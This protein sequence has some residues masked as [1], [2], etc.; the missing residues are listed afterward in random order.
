[1]LFSYAFFLEGVTGLAITN[2]VLMASKRTL[3][4]SRIGR[5]SHCLE[6]RAYKGSR[7]DWSQNDHFPLVRASGVRQRRK[8]QILGAQQATYLVAV[9]S[10]HGQLTGNPSIEFSRWDQAIP[11]FSCAKTADGNY[12]ASEAVP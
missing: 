7:D 6:G 12:V 4:G 1:M 2:H 5:K 9:E 10:H 3:G 8:G 11:D